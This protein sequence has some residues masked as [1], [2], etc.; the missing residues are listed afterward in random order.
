MRKVENAI[1]AS[2]AAGDMIA[3]NYHL[4]HLLLHDR[5]RAWWAIFRVA[6]ETHQDRRA[7]M[8]AL[9]GKAYIAR[10]TGSLIGTSDSD[11]LG[12][13]LAIQV[14]GLDGD[15]QGLTADE[16]RILEQWLPAR[17]ARSIFRPL[18]PLS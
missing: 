5:R 14:R 16:R 17:L 9:V 18:H 1:V 2:V 8:L 12:L 10:R 4:Q 7:A 6:A 15:G 13:L 11:L 3:A